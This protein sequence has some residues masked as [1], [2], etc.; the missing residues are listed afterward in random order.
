MQ[1]YFTNKGEKFM[2]MFYKGI[3][4]KIDTQAKIFTYKD[5]QDVPTKQGVYVMFE[6]GQLDNDGKLRIV[7]IGKASNLHDRL[8]NHF[9][10]KGKSIFRKHVQSALNT[11]SKEEVSKY[12]QDNISYAL[13]CVPKLMS[14]EELESTLTIILADYSKDLDV[15]NWLGL[16]SKNKTIQNYKIWNT[17]NCKTKKKTEIGLDKYL[18]DLFEIGLIKK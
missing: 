1:K 6:N 18:L 17:Q 5:L 13:I 11:N 10:G 14:T 9:N 4:T 16:S 15:G 7:R 2:T 12:I 8:V 3:K